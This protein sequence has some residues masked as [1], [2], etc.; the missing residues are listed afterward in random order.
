MKDNPMN[1]LD[2]RSVLDTQAQ[3]TC[4]A[5]I[6]HA[7]P[8]GHKTMMARR[9]EQVFGAF[10]LDLQQLFLART[11]LSSR[12]D[13]FS[14][15]DLETL[16]LKMEIAQ[17]VV[18]VDHLDFLLS[19]WSPQKRRDFV[20]MIEV[21]WKSPDLTPKTFIFFVQDDPVLLSRQWYNSHHQPRILPVDAFRAF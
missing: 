1:L 8:M 6:I 19:V 16:L 9:M 15:R 20:S 18:V 5:M 10:L 13:R 12:I 4:R 17:T 14:P 2:M 21:R 11:D 3:E 7:P